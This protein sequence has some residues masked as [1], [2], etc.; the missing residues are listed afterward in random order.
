MDYPDFNKYLPSLLD[1]GYLY[2]IAHLRGGGYGGYEWYKDGKM[3]RKQ[4]TF[5]DYIACAEYLIGREL[6]APGKLVAWGES[7]GGLTI[8]ASLN[9]RPELFQLALLGVP[10]VD[11]LSEMC[12]S[13][14]P[15]TTEE[16]DEWGDPHDKKYFDY[17]RQYDPIRNIDLAKDY[18]NMYI[19]SNRDDSL[20]GYWVPYNYY[21]KVK[22]ADV[23]V[24][25]EKS[26]MINIEMDYGHTGGTS[27][28]DK[29]AEM[30]NIYTVILD[31]TDP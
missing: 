9:L 16:Y 6:T 10:F 23:F 28:S 3:L 19:Y 30:S 5:R 18:P 27:P 14:T 25:G 7:A 20:V 13:S 31:H 15:L 12:D 4:N 1:R 21:M 22:E 2:C 29:R 26:I 8:A 24:S 17:M 11:V